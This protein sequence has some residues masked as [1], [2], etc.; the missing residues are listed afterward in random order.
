MMLES[1]AISSVA[2]SFGSTRKQIVWA[3]GQ[4][5]I[6][7]NFSWRAPSGPLQHRGPP[8]GRGAL[9][10]PLQAMFFVHFSYIDIV[11]ISDRWVHKRYVWMGIE[12]VALKE[13]ELQPGV[14]VECVPKFCYL[15][16]TLSDGRDLNEAARARVRCVHCAWTKFEEL[17]LMDGC[18]LAELG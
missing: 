6:M 11:T 9:A 17:Y 13:I 14:K 12:A 10:T 7:L 4:G 3:P 16:D 15:G 5:V 2:T 8:C 18:F 1:Q